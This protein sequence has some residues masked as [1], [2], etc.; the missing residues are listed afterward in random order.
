[1][2]D[3]DSFVAACI[4]ASDERE[5]RL[6]LKDV[7]ARAVSAPAAIAGALRP[8]RA[9]ITTLHVSPRLTIL[10]IVWAPGM[11]IQPHNHNTWATIG[12][13]SGGEDNTFFRRVEG[14]LTT[15]GGK[16]LRPGDTTLLGD[17]TIHAVHN[18]T[19]EHA[20]A[21]HVYG[22]DF[23]SIDRSEW[24]TETLEERPYSI[25]AT[26]RLFEEANAC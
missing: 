17:D 16:E 24:D 25:E 13:Y 21:I 5:P 12:L 2:F 23:F 11:S 22:G 6:A 4:A 9:G 15:S 14:G 10:N 18:P 3:L 1:M 8:E 7:V 20:G 26:L 19:P